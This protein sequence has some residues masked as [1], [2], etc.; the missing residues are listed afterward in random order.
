M[1]KNV[2]IIYSLPIYYCAGM[3]FF[4]GFQDVAFLPFRANFDA[5]FLKKCGENFDTVTYPKGVVGVN[6]RLAPCR[7]ISF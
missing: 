6:R 7:M 4:I 3:E 5:T 2:K 1:D